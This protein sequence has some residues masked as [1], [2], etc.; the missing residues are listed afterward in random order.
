M[1][2]CISLLLILFSFFVV[3]DRLSGPVI[4]PFLGA[5]PA[6]GVAPPLVSVAGCLFS[7]CVF[8]RS[9]L[10]CL[11]VITLHDLKNVLQEVF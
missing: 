3:Y 9:W 2:S 6:G 10:V 1:M 7:L 5:V 11:V 4:A 8:Q